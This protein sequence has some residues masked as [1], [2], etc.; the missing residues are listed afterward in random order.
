MDLD[1]SPGRDPF[2][3]D[4]SILHNG[5][6]LVVVDDCFPYPLSS[7]RFAEFCGVLDAFPNATVCSSGKVVPSLGCTRPFSG[8][9]REHI[10]TRPKHSGRVQLFDGRPNLEGRVVYSVFF[11]NISAILE[12]V[13]RDRAPFAFTLYPGGGF[14]LDAPDVDA[15]FERI[16]NSRYFH[17]VI[18]TQ[19][20]TRDYLLAKN[21][22]DPEKIRLVF[23][24]LLPPADLSS[25][26]EKQ[27]YGVHKP[28]IDICFAAWRYMLKGRDKGYDTFVEVAKLLAR[29]FDHVRFHAVG[30]WDPNDADVSA[31]GG[32]MRFHPPMS[33]GLKSFFRRMDLIVSPNA[34]FVLAPGKFDG[35]PTGCC[36]EAGLSGVAV[37]ASDVLNQNGPFTHGRDIL[38]TN[39]VA[40]DIAEVVGAAISDYDGLTELAARG[41]RTFARVF[42]WKSQLG[43]RLEIL[44][45]LQLLETVPCLPPPCQ[46][47]VLDRHTG[48][49]TME[50]TSAVPRRYHLNPETG[51]HSVAGAP[52]FPYSDGDGE[53]ERLLRFIR[54]ARDCSSTSTGLAAGIVDWPSYYHLSHLRSNLLRPAAE[55]LAGDV[56][57]VGAGCGA[58]TRFLGETA[59]S[60]VAVEGSPRRAEIAAAR[61]AGLPNVDVY[62]DHFGA[63]AASRKFDAIVCIGVMEYSPVFFNGLDPFGQMLALAAGHLAEE[64][65]LLIAIENR[66][67][68]K[69]F[70]GAP[71]DHTGIRFQGIEELYA[72]G[73]PRTLG[74]AEWRRQLEAAGLECA[75]FLY[76]FPDYKHPQAV[77]SDAAFDDPDLHAPE[78][79][80]HLT[81]PNQDRDYERLFSEELVWPVLAHNGIAQDMAN[82]FLIVARKSGSSR[83]CWQPSALAYQYGSGTQ[84]ADFKETRI[85]RD[86]SGHLVARRPIATSGQNV[87]DA[88]LCAGKPY[89]DGLYRQVNRPGWTHAAV[90]EWAD[91]WFRYLH[92]RATIDG[93]TL[94]GALVDCIPPNL[95][96][97]AGGAVQMF[98]T[99]AAAA[100]HPVSIEF[101]L[102]RGLVESF[103]RIR[104]CAAPQLHSMTIRAECA[105]GTME[106]LGVHLSPAHR[107][108]LLRMEAEYENATC[109]T[110]LDVA[111][112]RIRTGFTIRGPGPS[113][114]EHF[115]SQVYWRCGRD[116]FS[117]LCSRRVRNTAEGGMKRIRIEIPENDP[118]P[119]ELRLDLSDRPGVFTLMDIRVAASDG[120]ELWAWDHDPAAFSGRNEVIFLPLEGSTGVMVLMPGADPYLVLPIPAAVLVALRAGGVIEFR[121]YRDDPSSVVRRLA[122]EFAAVHR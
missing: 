94:P 35:F 33:E 120:R 95:V 37:C 64:G 88:P 7:F 3:A 104:T 10:A 51:V 97:T 58:L 20:L 48:L 8:V 105:F 44:S 28:T 2:L 57:E 47:P 121:I 62:C 21:L 75:A 6:P 40:A 5:L 100:P 60:V 92:S 23:G 12:A 63:F 9:I 77:L 112:D 72:E 69:Y 56:L 66:L 107:D 86:A 110:P 118:P 17:T 15:Q 70:A 14:R 111:A 101:V 76:P 117:E 36:V 18:V 81:S 49:I 1:L 65:Y 85:V 38:I 13:N 113:S 53:E 54:A 122:S 108:D 55:L 103:L 34:P 96:T 87:A 73:G 106:A 74:R 41:S 32:R 61:C 45:R 39:L 30:P 26:P 59:R 91:P 25:L 67:G 84:T 46:P 31:L 90:A 98:D 93:S 89:M 115:N 11:H 102:F 109:G 80:R 99:G 79:I 78:F 119:V 16:F 43:P 68:L 24:I 114:D 27:L 4:G 42:S 50:K 71:E 82:S 116:P 19:P 29:R 22:C 52:P 83:P